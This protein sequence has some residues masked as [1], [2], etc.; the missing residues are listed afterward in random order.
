M[1]PWK[2]KRQYIYNFLLVIVSL[3]KFDLRGLKICLEYKNKR[4]EKKIKKSGILIIKSHI[5]NSRLFEI[6]LCFIF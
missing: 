5:L 2:S 4:R 6:Y 1:L 3:L